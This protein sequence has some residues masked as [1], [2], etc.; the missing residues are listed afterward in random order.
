VTA[1]KGD[2]FIN[3]VL[4]QLRDI[5]DV[6]ARP[7]FGAHGLYAGE[8]FFAIACKSVLYFKT[9][10]KSRGAY[11]RRGMKP[12]QPNRKQTIKSYFQVPAD[13]LDSRGELE[14]WAR[15]AI[16]AARA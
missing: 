3:F 7:M 1:V 2:S 13:V 15:R 9:D 5:P 14:K 16:R 10:E 12:F 6:A 4:D 8:T 11:E